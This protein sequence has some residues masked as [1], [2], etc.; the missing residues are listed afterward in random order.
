MISMEQP[1]NMP[2]D[3]LGFF[4]NDLGQLDAYRQIART[5]RRPADLFIAFDISRFRPISFITELKLRKRTSA[6]DSR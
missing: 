5:L 4:G 6:H 2:M 3:K 1:R